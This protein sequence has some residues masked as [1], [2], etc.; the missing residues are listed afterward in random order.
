M[1]KAVLFDCFGVLTTDSWRM[2]VDTLENP[3][4][5]EVAHELNRQRGAGFIDESDFLLQLSEAT[6]IDISELKERL[7]PSTVKNK[8]LL[9]FI[10]SLKPDYTIGIISNIGSDWITK[11]LLDPKEQELFDEMILSHEVGMIKPDPRIFMLACERL[12]T[13]PHETLLVD[14]IESYCQA[15]KAEGLEAVVY[16]SLAQAKREIIHHLNH[17]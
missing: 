15:A 8:P 6:N 16:D 3:Q 10:K 5:A 1:I 14:D 4:L 9:E 2:F 17:E 13:G 7:S 12:R 11:E